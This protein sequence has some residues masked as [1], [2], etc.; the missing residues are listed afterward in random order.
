MLAVVLGTAL[1]AVAASPAPS[2]DAPIAARLTLLPEA[3]D[4]S[5]AAVGGQTSPDAGTPELP[6]AEATSPAEG[7]ASAS[8]APAAEGAAA[9][10]PAPE[11]EK[12]EEEKKEEPQSIAGP[13]RRMDMGT[14][15]AG[16]APDFKAYVPT[17]I[18]YVWPFAK[19]HELLPGDVRIPLPIWLMA[20]GGGAAIG[21]GLPFYAL[22]RTAESR[23][24]NGDPSLRTDADRHALIGYGRTMEAVGVTLWAT[25]GALIATSWTLFYVFGFQDKPKG[26][27]Y[28]LNVGPGGGN[29]SVEF[30]LP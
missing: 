18:R 2:F 3:G 1:A 27:N 25:G 7:A 24:V 11:A 21:A 10:A 12:K 17:R 16:N 22:A 20:V 13:R 9:A 15:A 19:D 29:V 5:T 14:P 8:S 4:V 28:S 23:L 30:A 6:P 26:L